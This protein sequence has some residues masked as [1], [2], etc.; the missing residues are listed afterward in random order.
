MIITDFKQSHVKEAHALA[1]SNYHE[2]REYVEALPEIE[3]LPDLSMFAGNGLGVAAIGDDGCLIGFLC[4]YEPWENAF[5]SKAIGTFSPIHS[6][7]AIKEK[8]AEIYKRMYQYAAEKW[9]KQGI[10]YH[11]VALYDHDSDA[12]G[13]MFQYGFGLRC[14]DAIRNISPINISDSYKGLG[15]TLEELHKDSVDEVRDLRK[16]LSEHLG[17]SPCFMYSSDADFHEWLL[18]A[19]KRDSRLF[20]ARDKNKVVAF[21]EIQDGGE[22]FV[23]YVPDMKNICGAFCMPEYRGKYIFQGL[24]NYAMEVLKGEGVKRLG[25][26]F[27]SFNPTANAFWLKYFDAY[28]HSV[29]RRIDECVIHTEIAIAE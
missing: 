17:K 4:C 15:I 8:R 12:L 21:V 24:L 14:V 18:R 27:E 29:V 2:E 16:L 25:V 23:T 19:E 22:N 28:T 9:V 6:H 1:W 7:G 5:D 3:W 10:T 13:A 20:I 11:G 26:D